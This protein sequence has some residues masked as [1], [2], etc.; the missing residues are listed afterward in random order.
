MKASSRA[1]LSFNSLP[2]ERMLQQGILLIF[3]A[4]LFSGGTAS[5]DGAAHCATSEHNSIAREDHLSQAAE[6]SSNACPERR[7]AHCRSADI[8]GVVEAL[9]PRRMAESYPEKNFAEG[10]KNDLPRMIE[11]QK[12]RNSPIRRATIRV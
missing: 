3:K 7:I 1:R 5:H 8:V 11:N 2:V 10:R 9:A 12:S 4:H 6:Q